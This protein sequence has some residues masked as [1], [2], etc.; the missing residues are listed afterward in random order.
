MKQHHKITLFILSIVCCGLSFS[1][2]SNQELSM[3]LVK[4]MKLGESALLGMT[5][6]MMHGGASTEHIS[7]VEKTDSNII[8]VVY[9]KILRENIS[10]NNL[11]DSLRF[12]SSSAGIKYTE[13]GFYGLRKQFNL[14]QGANPPEFSEEEKRMVANFFNSAAGEALLKSR[15]LQTPKVQSIV[16]LTLK[17]IYDGCNPQNS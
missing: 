11:E 16:S 12:Y 5:A 14:T 15:L 7:C 17:S 8:N 4:A 6:S 2:P 9:S 13:S 1:E 10:D 3:R